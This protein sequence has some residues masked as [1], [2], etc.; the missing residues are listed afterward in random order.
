MHYV[1]DRAFRMYE[2]NNI[3]MLI[4]EI[5]NHFGIASDVML[6]LTFNMH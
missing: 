6:S 2:N 1:Y 5:M 3:I 4:H